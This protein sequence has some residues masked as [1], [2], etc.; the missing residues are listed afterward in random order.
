IFFASNIMFFLAN[1]IV[2]DQVVD[3][4]EVM[5]TIRGSYITAVS[6]GYILAPGLAG[7]ILAR[8]GF[9]ALYGLA[10][11]VLIPLLFLLL[12][13]RSIRNNS[14]E[15]ISTKKSLSFIIKNK[16]LRNI[17]GANFILQFFYSWMVIYTPIFLHET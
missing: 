6:M 5:G 12:K 9:S 8:L 11:F 1:D 13:T 16:G 17:V 4:D 10:G 3:S 7:F 2:I 14:Q 15:K